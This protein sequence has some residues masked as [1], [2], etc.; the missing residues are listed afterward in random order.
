[1]SMMYGV[2]NIVAAFAPESANEQAQQ[3]K[4]APSSLGQGIG[5]AIGGKKGQAIG[6]AAETAAG[7]PGAINEGKFGEAGENAADLMNQAMDAGCTD[8]E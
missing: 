5:R 2:G 3:M 6:G 8:D 4:D 1:M 7:I